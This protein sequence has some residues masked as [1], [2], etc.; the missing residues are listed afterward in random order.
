M[1][2]AKKKV[3][4]VVTKYGVYKAVFEPEP[5]MGGYAVEAPK[6]PG[7]V[8]WGKNLAEARKMIAECIE[9]VIEARIIADAAEAKSIRIV[10]PITF[11]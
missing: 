11:A 10:R 8:S 4:E 6:V 1:K 7:A 3:E 2:Q 9:G 5:D